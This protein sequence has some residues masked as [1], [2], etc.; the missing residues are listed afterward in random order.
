MGWKSW[1]AGNVA[2][3]SVKTA[4]RDRKLRINIAMNVAWKKLRGKLR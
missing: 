2:E 1:S 3:A 4:L